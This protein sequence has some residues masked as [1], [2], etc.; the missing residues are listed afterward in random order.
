MTDFVREAM[1]RLDSSRRIFPGLKRNVAGFI[2][3]KDRKTLGMWLA[4]IWTRGFLLDLP[5][6]AERDVKGSVA[7]HA[8]EME[9]PAPE[10][11]W[12]IKP[13]GPHADYVGHRTFTI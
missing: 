4:T 11:K 8:V 5:I 9:D 7:N 10:R 12:Q 6:R 2:T 3:A 13:R 1:T